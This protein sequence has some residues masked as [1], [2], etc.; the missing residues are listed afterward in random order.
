MRVEGLGSIGGVVLALVLPGCSLVQAPTYV[1]APG[2]VPAPLEGALAFSLGP[3]DAQ[4]CVPDIG[5]AL[6]ELPHRGHAFGFL[7]SEEAPLGGFLRHWQGVQR[8]TTAGAQHLFLSRSGSGTAVIV[9][10]IASHTEGTGP[11]AAPTMSGGPPTEDRVVGRIPFDPGFTH[12]GGLSLVGGVLAVPMDSRHG[13]QVAFYDVDDPEHPRR[14]GTLAHRNISRESDTNQASAVGVVRLREGRYLVALGV[15]SSKMLDFYRSRGPSLRDSALA[16]EYLGTLLGL[17]VG[18]YQNLALVSQCDGTLYLVGT[19]NTAFPPP[20]G[21]WN[22]V[23]WY[24]LLGGPGAMPRLSRG[25]R[26]R[27]DC[28]ECNLAAAAGLFL[29]PGGEVT[30][31]ASQ[32]WKQKRGHW[33]RLEEF[34]PVAPAP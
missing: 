20:S 2:V 19:H 8:A 26:R 22:H 27:V 21:G 16:F 6:G 28:E 5:R 29:G 7:L 4:P 30:L 15:H 12:A 34:G 25:T 24:R 17:D 9:V 13:S 32:F 1:P 23:H 3:A 33:V 18:G 10:K 11:L 14:L 31:Y